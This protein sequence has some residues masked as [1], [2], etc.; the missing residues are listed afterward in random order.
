MH[1]SSQANALETAFV[2]NR[3]RLLR[4]LVARG[5]G[6]DAEDILQ[7]LWLRL[8]Q[9][10]DHAAAARLAYMMRTADRL[11][12][13]RFRS[14]RQSQLRERRWVEALPGVAEGVS[15]APDAGRVIESREHA[16]LVEEALNE[17]GER[18][19]AIF[20]RHRIDGTA[21][22]QIAAEFSISLSTV[23]SDLRRAYRAVDE[24]RKFIDEA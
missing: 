8:S 21:Q 17:V 7:E 12:I 22:R 18:P 5:A 6:D 14:A 13:D 24:V 19:A 3:S 20:R 10:A 1:P 23:E 16:R 11:L 2:A 9:A 15:P 4:F